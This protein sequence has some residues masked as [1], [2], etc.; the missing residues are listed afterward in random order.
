MRVIGMAAIAG[1]ALVLAGVVPGNPAYAD[2]IAWHSCRTEHADETGAALDAAGAQ[3]AELEVP[4]NY[5]DPDDRSITLAIARRAATDTAH[6]LGTL[7]VNVGAPETS[8]Q[9]AHPGELTA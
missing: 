5:A 9:G 3:C 8:R 2:Q 4:L 1:P 7:V 6:K